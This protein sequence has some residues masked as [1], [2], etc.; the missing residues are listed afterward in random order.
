MLLSSGRR[1]FGLLGVDRDQPSLPH[2]PSDTLL[3][4]RHAAAEL[5]LLEDLPDL[6]GEQPVGEHRDACVPSAPATGRAVR[7]VSR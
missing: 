6:L 1:A 4:D 7:R 2:Q 5:E 3:A